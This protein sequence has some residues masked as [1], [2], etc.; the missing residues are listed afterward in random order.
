M[1]EETK[2]VTYT[3]DTLGRLT[4]E[5][6]SGENAITYTY[7]AHNNRAEMT[8]GN[9]KT[10]YQ[11]NKNEELLRTNT[12]N[13]DTNTNAV[14]LYKNDKKG[15]LYFNH[16]GLKRL[17]MEKGSIESMYKDDVE[18]VNFIKENI[19]FYKDKVLFLWNSGAIKKVKTLSKK[20]DGFSGIRVEENKIYVETYKGA[21]SKT[22]SQIDIEGTVVKRIY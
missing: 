21:F 10:A 22:I 5:E 9:Q 4:K 13:T 14:I 12:L 7:D 1:E 2:T 11:Y 8:V 6:R 20:E 19:L 16:S 15:Y 17:H 3:Y 18:G